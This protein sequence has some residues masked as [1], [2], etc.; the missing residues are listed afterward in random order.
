MV[1]FNNH[2]DIDLD[3]LT[4]TVA[5]SRQQL[6]NSVRQ[7]LQDTNSQLIGAQQQRPRDPT[8]DVV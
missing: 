7:M 6:K 2:V 3:E 8:P 5:E 4:R 1:P